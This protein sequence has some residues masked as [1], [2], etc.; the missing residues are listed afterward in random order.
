MKI[1]DLL[2]PDDIP[3]DRIPSLLL[4]WHLGSRARRHMSRRRFVTVSQA[5]GGAGGGRALDIGC[6][7]GYNL[8]LL[9]ANGFAPIG[10]DIV[11]N[12]FFAA[13]RI[14]EANS[15]AIALA[16]AD[17]SSLP[18]ASGA[19][20]AVTSIE[21]L[22]HIYSDDRRK[23]VQEFFR[24]LRPGGVLS[25]STPNSRSAVE[26]GKRLIVKVSLLKRFFPPMCYPAG[27]VERAAYHPYSY[28]SPVGRSELRGLL[29]ESG[30]ERIETSAI[31]FVTKNIP[32][33]LFPVARLLEALFERIPGLRG[34]AS[35]LVVT[36]RRPL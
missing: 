6:G 16:Q 23:A 29:R 9:G 2:I 7:W 3:P 11:S 35:T 20:D 34:L 32:D 10:I 19:F 12:D 8:L 14:A 21:T 28:H 13:R 30:F 26:L 33:F 25:M 36:A 27:K 31:I 18:F 5:L 24:V 4:N 17:A 15:S 22:E 1:P